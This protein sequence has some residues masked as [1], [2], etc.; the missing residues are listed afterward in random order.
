MNKRTEN[1]RWRKLTGRFLGL[2]AVL[3]SF[4]P[5]FTACDSQVDTETDNTE[6]GIIIPAEPNLPGDNAPPGITEIPPPVIFNSG[7]GAV[8]DTVKKTIKFEVLNAADLSL[9]LAGSTGIV[10]TQD[11]SFL[12]WDSAK[13]ANDFTITI[14]A[15]LTDK[16][17][18]IRWR[19][20]SWLCLLDTYLKA[21]MD[22]SR[23]KI[24]LDYDNEQVVSVKGTLYDVQIAGTWLNNDPSTGK[25]TGL[26]D[27][28]YVAQQRA[29]R[30]WLK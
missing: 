18:N 17:L 26:N 24:I 16:Y 29:V 21:K 13:Y 25:K 3:L 15:P 5:A 12:V 30:D 14:I 20:T 19:G 22:I 1:L 9:A 6:A 8:V 2:A 4:S 11:D 27:D 23:S 28:W 10:S 7:T